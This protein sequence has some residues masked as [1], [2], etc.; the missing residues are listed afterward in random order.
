M[1]SIERIMSDVTTQRRGVK[2][3]NIEKGNRR[4]DKPV[5]RRETGDTRSS[6]SGHQN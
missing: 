1:P 3:L 2:S 4:C 6:D 5:R